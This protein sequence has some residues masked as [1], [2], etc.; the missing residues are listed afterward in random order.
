MRTLCTATMFACCR[1]ATVMAS[2]R[3]RSTMPSPSNRPGCH[4]LDG[5]ATIQRELAC[6]EH[7]RH[8]AVSELALELEFA[9]QRDSQSLDDW[10]PERID[11][12]RGRARC[13]LRGSGRG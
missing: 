6:A 13:L 9:R 4:D 7:G 12:I 8:A 11:S 5:D 10:G 2:W 1:F 3:N